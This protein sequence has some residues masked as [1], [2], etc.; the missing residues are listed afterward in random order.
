MSST[1]DNT[2]QTAAAENQQAK[3]RVIVYSSNRLVREE[4]KLA[5]GRKVAS[6]LPELEIFEFATQPA[7]FEALD[8]E[9]FDVAVLDGEAV[10][11]GM[12]IAHQMKEEI[13]SAA[14]VVLLIARRDDAW[15][16]GWS[17]AEAISAYPIDPLRLPEAVAQ[18]VRNHRSGA[19]TVLSSSLTVTPGQSSRPPGRD[20]D[21]H[22]VPTEPG[23]DHAPGRLA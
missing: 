23:T 19:Q 22:D 16:A 8:N 7:L 20:D 1:V 10:P 13:P 12:G 4:V 5:L 11:G 15:M 21:G 9:P 2:E 14:P 17:R 3:L 6:D 18:V